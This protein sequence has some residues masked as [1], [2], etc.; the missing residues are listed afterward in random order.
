MSKHWRMLLGAT[1]AV[2][3]TV[4]LAQ[5]EAHDAIKQALAQQ[6]DPGHQTTG[7][8]AILPWMDPSLPPAR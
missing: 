8:P 7:D 2:M 3:T 1:L 4:A 5:P 6:R